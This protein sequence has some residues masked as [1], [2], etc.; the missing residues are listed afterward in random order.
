MSSI[1]KT[2][3]VRVGV[4]TDEPIRLEG[5]S[6]IFEAHPGEGR[7]QLAPV[8][9]NLDELLADATLAY[10]LID[11]N[12]SS[13]GVEIV[14]TIRRR[15][16]DMRLIVIGPEGDDQMVM[17]LIK[18]GARAFLSFKAGP[19]TVR[20]AVE[21]VTGGSIWAP[22]R[23]LS[24]LIDQL[25]G[26]DGAGNHAGYLHLTNRERQVLE[27]ILMARSN[28]EIA[29]QLGI[30]ERTVHGHV[31]RLLRKTGAENRISL[32]MMASNPSLLRSAGVWMDRRRGERRRSGKVLSGI[33]TKELP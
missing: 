26:A 12:S 17:D 25:L 16:P 28:R 9:G 20:Q 5:L 7:T 15:R 31:G 4:L 33:F 19:K 30:E 6:S 21:V 1:S 13:A 29:Q 14:E 3:P 27:L 10:L 8:F 11:L 24:Q 22:R 32:L 2:E 18:A 23:L